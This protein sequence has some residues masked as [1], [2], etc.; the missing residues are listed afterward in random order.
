MALCTLTEVKNYY[1]IA[2]TTEDALLTVLTERVSQQIETY[3][4]RIFT[5]A[6]Y[7]EYYDGDRREF[8]YT[9]QYPIT[10]VSG[11]WN[12]ATWTWGADTLVAAA[13]Y[14]VSTNG[15]RVIL[16]TGYFSD[17]TENVKV[18]YT[19]GY[20][21]IPADLVQAAV[22]ETV[23]RYKYREDIGLAG[24]THVDGT[25]SYLDRKLL[26]QTV[27]ILDRYRRRDVV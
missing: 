21:T 19:G 27:E 7:T 25:V 10:S 16:K 4:D 5:S 13:D 12:D 9:N 18:I 24:K 11:I 23:H 1:G 17:Y 22:E 8:L 15:R 20:T 14:R 6:E 2:K 26:P 3:C